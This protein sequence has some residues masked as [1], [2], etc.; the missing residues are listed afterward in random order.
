MSSKKRLMFVLSLLS[1]LCAIP[2]TASSKGSLT[3]RLDGPAL[4][5]GEMLNPGEY[6]ISWKSH[7]PEV[8]LAFVLNGMRVEAHGKLVD[9][10]HVSAYDAILVEKDA[11]GRD[12]VK[13]IRMQGRKTVIVVE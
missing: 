3:V 5:A 13:E 2:A 1:L 7:S 12:V 11:A 8:D 10:D 9:R 6:R 4:V